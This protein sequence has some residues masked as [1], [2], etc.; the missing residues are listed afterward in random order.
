LAQLR[1][2]ACEP[3]HNQIELFVVELPVIHSDTGIGN[4]LFHTG[5]THK[6]LPT[7]NTLTGRQNIMGL[8]TVATFL[9][10]HF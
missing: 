3:I 2:L 8:A 10:S 6:H 4:V 9:R 7:I 5:V 1:K